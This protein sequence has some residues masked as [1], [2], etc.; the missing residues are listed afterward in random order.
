MA[1]SKI[2]MPLG[3]SEPITP[4]PTNYPYVKYVTYGKIVVIS[5]SV[6]MSGGGVYIS[7]SGFP[8]APSYTAV[9]VLNDTGYAD[10]D[11]TGKF[12]IRSNTSGEHYVFCALV[13][14]MAD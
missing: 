10:I 7:I 12:G 4:D 11:T 1:N 5:A 13:Y 6:T 2:A 8:K 3:V 9:P 14:I